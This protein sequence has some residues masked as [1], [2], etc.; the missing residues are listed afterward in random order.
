MYTFPTGSPRL[1]SGKDAKSNVPSILHGT[2]VL[3]TVIQAYPFPQADNCTWR[4]CDSTRVCTIIERNTYYVST[5]EYRRVMLVIVDVLEN[6]FGR[7]ELEVT[8]GIGPVLTMDFYLSKQE[9]CEYIYQLT[10]AHISIGD[11]MFVF[12]R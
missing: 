4:R 9:T 10:Q 6:N 2:A 11:I 5:V 8:N 1:T 12:T 3:T 7:Y